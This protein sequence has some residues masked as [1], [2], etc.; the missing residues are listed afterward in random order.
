MSGPSRLLTHGDFLLE[1]PQ[2]GCP[3]C[4]QRAARLDGRCGRCGVRAHV[5]CLVMPGDIADG[6]LTVCHGCRS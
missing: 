2:T 6:A 1:V 4:R 3:V 5:A